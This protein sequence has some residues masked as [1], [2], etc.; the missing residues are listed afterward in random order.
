[1]HPL[2]MVT[3]QV[4]AGHIRLDVEFLVVDVP[5]SY[6]A[7]IGR[8]WIHLMRA[9]PLTYP[10]R[11]CFPTLKGTMEISK[12]HVV[13]RSCLIVTIKGKARREDEESICSSREVD[14]K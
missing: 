13:S 3:V 5:F 4:S 7:I 1:M 9:I 6:N 2:G 12:D 8:T 11:I 10:Q 14:L